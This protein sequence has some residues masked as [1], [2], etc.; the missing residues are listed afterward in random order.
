MDPIIAV[1]TPTDRPM[2]YIKEKQLYDPLYG[3]ISAF[4]A[5]FK[6]LGGC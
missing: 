2:V 5:A 6:N 4:K 3:V 1:E